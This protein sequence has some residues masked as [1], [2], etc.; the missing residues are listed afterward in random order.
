[1]KTIDTLFRRISSDDLSLPDIDLIIGR[2]SLCIASGRGL[3]ISL[4]SV[5]IGDY[6][7][8]NAG[9]TITPHSVVIRGDLTTN[10]VQFGDIELKRAFLQVSLEAKSSEKANDLI[11]GGEVAF[12]ALVFDAAVHLYRS[13]EGSKK[14]LEWTVLAA[15]T[16]KNDALQLSKVVPE[17]AGTPLDLSLTQA[18][19]VAASRDD[20]SLGNMI[21][22]GFAF[23]EGM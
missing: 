23:H 8:L 17:V 13:P 12:S 11:V 5:S 1:M 18:V 22:S 21:T 14:S 7:S 10:V 20:P 2:A 6:T 16:V 15:L 19:F 3:S 4:N 9:L